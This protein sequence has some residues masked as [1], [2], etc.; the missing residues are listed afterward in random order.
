M[1]QSMR[2]SPPLP[3]DC[4]GKEQS[5]N[6]NES[7]PSTNICL[8]QESMISLETLAKQLD[9]SSPISTQEQCGNRINE[10]PSNH[11]PRPRHRFGKNDTARLAVPDD[12]DDEQDSIYS[13]PGNMKLQQ[14]HDGKIRQSKFYFPEAENGVNQ[15]DYV[16][17]SGDAAQS[18]KLEPFHDGQI[19]QSKFYFPGADSGVNQRHYEDHSGDGAQPISICQSTEMEP[20]HRARVPKI[21]AV[22]RVDGGSSSLGF[23]KQGEDSADSGVNQRHYEDHSG[24]GAQPISICQSTEMEPAHRARVPKIFAVRRVDGGSSSLGFCKQGEDSLRTPAVKKAD[25]VKRKRPPSL[26]LPTHT[27]DSHIG[28]GSHPLPSPVLYLTPPEHLQA[29]AAA[30]TQGNANGESSWRWWRGT[31]KKIN[32]KSMFRRLDTGGVEKK[33]TIWECFC[34]VELDI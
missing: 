28:G 2:H 14:T 30:D 4:R 3:M 23:C 22:R 1:N 7:L 17:N 19:R 25:S 10:L 24:D 6:R 15:R 21:F 18:M 20:A 8:Q 27:S 31:L 26:S 29:P 16:Q 9:P 12:N 32:G 34:E 13:N 11:V 5:G 33:K